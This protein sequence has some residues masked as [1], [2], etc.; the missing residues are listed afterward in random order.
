MWSYIADRCL[1]IESFVFRNTGRLSSVNSCCCWFTWLTGGSAC[2]AEPAA[3]S[4]WGQWSPGYT[5]S[6]FFHRYSCPWL[7]CCPGAHL[8]RSRILVATGCKYGSVC[9]AGRFGFAV[10]W[11]SDTSN[12][13]TKIEKVNWATNYS[14]Q[15]LTGRGNV[16]VTLQTTI[17]DVSGSNLIP[18]NWLFWVVLNISRDFKG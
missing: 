2:R 4:P 6:W 3:W 13:V 9:V 18:K 15:A 17:R 5:V 10:L 1:L 14:A 16:A 12:S 7:F 8:L 11:K